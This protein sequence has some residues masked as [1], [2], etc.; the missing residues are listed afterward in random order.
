MFS[1]KV[2][3]LP[4]LK[5]HF[6]WFSYLSLQLSKYTLSNDDVPH[7]D[8]ELV[9]SICLIT[10][11]TVKIKCSIYKTSDKLCNIAPQSVNFY[12]TCLS[13]I[14]HACYVLVSLQ[15]TINNDQTYWSFDEYNSSNMSGKFDLTF[16]KNIQR[17]RLFSSLYYKHLTSCVT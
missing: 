13:V 16:Y 12:K 7:N 4:Q 14:W 5:K 8:T 3:E 9:C 10:N 2:S 11:C 15:V 17:I 6:H 1:L